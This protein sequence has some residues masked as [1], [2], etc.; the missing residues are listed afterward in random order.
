[1]IVDEEDQAKYL[2]LVYQAMIVDE[3]DQASRVF[4]I[5]GQAI[6]HSEPLEVDRVLTLGLSSHG[7]RRRRL[8]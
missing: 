5:A 3:E 4:L 2:L 7:S 6:A 1:M 8:S